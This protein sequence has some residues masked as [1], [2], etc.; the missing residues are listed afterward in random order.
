MY[1]VSKRQREITDKE[2][3]K[4]KRKVIVGGYN[5]GWLAS[6]RYQQRIENGIYKYVDRSYERDS[7]NQ[8]QYKRLPIPYR[9]FKSNYEYRKRTG[10]WDSLIQTHFSRSNLRR[11]TGPVHCI[12][13][14]T[15]L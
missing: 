4:N 15:F 3:K 6:K 8:S 2:K 13:N 10:N 5:R 12:L 14:K 1:K 9:S 11:I 7:H